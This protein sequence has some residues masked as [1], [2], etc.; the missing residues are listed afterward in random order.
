ML[1]VQKDISSKR[2]VPKQRKVYIVEIIIIIYMATAPISD[3]IYEKLKVYCNNKGVKIK[4]TVNQIIT[5]F[6]EEVNNEEER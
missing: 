6:L 1:Q 2:T 5:D 3:S 4:D